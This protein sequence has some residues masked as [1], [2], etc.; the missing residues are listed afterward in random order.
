[1]LLEMPLFWAGAT[2]AAF[3]FGQKLYL[4]TGKLP[5]IPPIFTAILLLISGLRLTG[6]SYDRYMEGGQYLHI[7]LGP[8]VVMLA[9]PLY[10]QLRAMGQIWLRILLAVTLGSATTVLTAWTLVVWWLDD[11]MVAT[12]MWTKSITTPVAVSV[13]SQLGGD[14]ALVAASVIITGI[15]GVMLIVPLLRLM[16][17]DSPECKGLTLG[18]CAH[19]I[20]TSRAM[21]LGASESAYAAL[22]MTLTALLHAVALPLILS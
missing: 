21:E 11:P 2:I 8:I 12:A 22:G 15:F 1:M 20:G 10:T 5:L 13:T 4:A 19:A 14:P 9:V 18:V 16:R 7:L 3:L 6:T 17:M